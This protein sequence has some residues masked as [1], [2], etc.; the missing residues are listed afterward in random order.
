MLFSNKE[1]GGWGGGVTDRDSVARLFKMKSNAWVTGRDIQ[2]QG[3][4]L[5]VMLIIWYVD[6]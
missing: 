4:C 5:F 1:G 6:N 3:V 2:G